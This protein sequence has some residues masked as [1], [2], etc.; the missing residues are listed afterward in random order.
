M[1]MEVKSYFTSK[2]YVNHMGSRVSL[3]VSRIHK[4]MQF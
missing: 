1:T 4:Q 2:P 3:R